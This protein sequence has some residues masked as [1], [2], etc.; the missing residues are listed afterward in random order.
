MPAATRQ[1]TAI[2]ADAASVVRGLTSRKT[3]EPSRLRT[4][5][6]SAAS[7]NSIAAAPWQ[8]SDGEY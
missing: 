8:S 5:A 3:P 7:R 4:R 2:Q 1:A 6:A